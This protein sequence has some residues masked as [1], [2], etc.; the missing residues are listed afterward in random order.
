LTS[1]L[2]AVYG[3]LYVI[4]QLEDYSLLVG[5]AVLV[6]ALAS[7]MYVTRNVNWYGNGTE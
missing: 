6:V 4:L 3:A 2:A 1:G 5:T 7:V